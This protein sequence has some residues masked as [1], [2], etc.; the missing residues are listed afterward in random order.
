[1]VSHTQPFKST[2]FHPA[3]SR[4]E[5]TRRDAIIKVGLEDFRKEKTPTPTP[6]PNTTPTTATATTP[7]TNY[8]TPNSNDVINEL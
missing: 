4:Q 3:Q 5:Y 6:T 8:Y 7:T 1:M 2:S